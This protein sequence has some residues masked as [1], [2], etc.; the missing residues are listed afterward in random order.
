M[1]IEATAKEIRTLLEL[2]ELDRIAEQPGAKASRRN[3]EAAANCLPKGVL[4]RYERLLALGRRPAVAAI[5]GGAC[6][7]CHIRL[8]TM[9]ESKTRRAAA[10]HTCPHC[11]RMLYVPELVREDA[12]AEDGRTRRAGPAE[13]TAPR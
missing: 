6:L 12:H 4:D 11:Q 7:G 9:V 2:A 10:I 3:R 1:K 5:E 8:P 13:P